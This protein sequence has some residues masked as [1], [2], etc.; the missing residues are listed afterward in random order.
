MEL[1]VQILGCGSSSGVP[2]VG[3]N[4][5]ACNPNN[6]RNRRL[7]SSIYV[8]TNNTDILIDATPDLRQQL[9][10]ANITNLDAVFITHTH[11]D[12]INGIDDFRF[13]NVLMNKHIN[14]YASK[15]SIND[16]KERFSYVFEELSPEANG[17]YYKPCLIPN[18]V[19]K[20]FLL[21]ALLLDDSLYVLRR[22]QAEGIAHLLGIY[23]PDSSAPGLEPAEFTQVHDFSDILPSNAA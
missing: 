16:I 18:V 19:K 1:S 8:K 20:N 10:N 14:L 6:P 11:A 7:R 2:A 21:N 22:A 12:H 9:L 23:K 5:G 4:W 15:K 13:L 17:F 3:N